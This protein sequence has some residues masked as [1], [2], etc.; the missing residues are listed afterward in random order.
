MN[1]A[2]S[3]TPFPPVQHPPKFLPLA[4]MG[5]SPP[6]AP[7][8]R[9][10]GAVSKSPT[11]SEVGYSD[12]PLVDPHLAPCIVALPQPGSGQERHAKSPKVRGP[13]LSET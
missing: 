1:I 5:L 7:A 3:Q 4:T 10:D 13:E 2:H 11:D 8:A 12:D 9:P 6:R